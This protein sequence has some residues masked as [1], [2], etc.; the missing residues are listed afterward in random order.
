MAFPTPAIPKQDDPAVDFL[1]ESVTRGD[2]T[3]QV[4]NGVLHMMIPLAGDM[5]GNYGI[6][7]IALTP[8]PPPFWSLQRD[9]LL[10]QTPHKESFWAG[11]IGIAISKVAAMGFEVKGDVPL[12]IK[13]GQEVI[14]YADGRQ[15]GYINFISKHLR[16]FLTTDNGAFFEVIRATRAYASPVVG[17]RHLDSHRCIRTGDPVIPVIYR[18][19][20]NV[21]HE[22]KYFEVVSIADMP[23]SGETFNGVG[24]CAASR[25]Y[26]SIYKLASIEWYLREKV[27][28]LQPLAIHIVNGILDAQLKDSIKA[29]KDGAIAR[30][31]VAHMGAVVIGIPAEQQPN[32]V[33]IPLAELPDGFNRQEEF[34]LSI[35]AY[36]NAIGLDPQDLQPLTGRPL[37]SGMQ[38]EILHEKS[39]GRGLA[40]WRPQFVHHVNEFV[41]A[42]GTT[43]SFYDKD[44][45]DLQAKANLSK[46]L[47]E[48][49]AARIDAGITTPEEER[50]VLV[51][52]DELPK[53]FLTEDKTTEDSLSDTEKPEEGGIDGDAPDKTAET[54]KPAPPETQEDA[55]AQ[56]EKA[57]AFDF[58]DLVKEMESAQ[59][60][61]KML[62]SQEITEEDMVLEA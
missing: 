44:F 58:E 55:Q 4:R 47:T 28:G 16:D 46:T 20:R 54:E 53:E 31:V 40:S 2:I 7:Q 32:L 10:R 9:M 30:G 50:Q 8:N 39:K 27:S 29:A 11:A 35:L 19:R 49:S 52:L 25:A 6:D 21:Y 23:D 37:G 17:I 45:R 24:L 1:N 41:L 26:Y 22:L 15:V 18:D 59:E 14:L 51:D 36:A 5:W 13:R 38:T 61:Y 57:V 42:T 34:D 12:R 33:T 56:T 43:F 48:T 60:L 62:D 3:N